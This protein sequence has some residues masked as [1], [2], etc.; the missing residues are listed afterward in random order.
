MRS[1][2]LV[3]NPHC[4]WN[5][6][7]MVDNGQWKLQSDHLKLLTTCGCYQEYDGH[8]CSPILRDTLRL[9]ALIVLYGCSHPRV[10]CA[11]SCAIRPQHEK[12]NS[13]LRVLSEQSVN[14]SLV[15]FS[16]LLVVWFDRSDGGRR[17]AV[18]C[19]CLLSELRRLG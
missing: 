10:L 12:S 3:R 6:T 7:M 15:L 14:L 8:M 9:V 17:L 11:L 19:C 16:I 18:T 2:A 4:C 5:R 13:S 1:K